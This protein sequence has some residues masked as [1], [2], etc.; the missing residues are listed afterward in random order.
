MISR[1]GRYVRSAR[2]N[3][4]WFSETE[5]NFPDGQGE[6]MEDTRIALIGIIV[7]DLSATEKICISPS[8]SRELSFAEGEYMSKNGL[9]C[10]AW[11][12][13]KG[14]YHVCV[15]AQDGVDFDYHFKGREVL[16]VKREGNTLVAQVK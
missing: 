1:A 2:E 10:V 12:Y 6:I 13:D 16:F 15:E 8:F 4:R 14:V 7:E 9:L 3:I 11:K 5:G